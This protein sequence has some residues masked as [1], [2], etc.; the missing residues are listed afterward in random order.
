MM[1]LSVLSPKTKQAGLDLYYQKIRD[2]SF[3]VTGNTLN[4]FKG[5]VSLFV[6]LHGSLLAFGLIMMNLCILC[7]KLLHSHLCQISLFIFTAKI[8]KNSRQYSTLR[9]L[10]YGE[11]ILSSFVDPLAWHDQNDFD[12][13]KLLILFVNCVVFKW[14]SFDPPRP[15]NLLLL[16]SSIH[17]HVTCYYKSLETWSYIHIS[18]LYMS[19]A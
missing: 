3:P 6:Q 7:C 2:K 5:G 11:N 14:A 15:R 17:N 13:C 1:S 10:W 19:C 18:P 16:T 8:K 9:C 12:L 4:Y